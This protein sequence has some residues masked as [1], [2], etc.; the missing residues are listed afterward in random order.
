[1]RNSVS[2]ERS[3]IIERDEEE[4]VEQQ[5]CRSGDDAGSGSDSSY[6]HQLGHG[7]Q[8]LFLHPPVAAELQ[9]TTGPSFHCG[10]CT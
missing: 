8:R 6:T 9:V 10:A 5:R 1:M 4:E 7:R 2:E 3:L